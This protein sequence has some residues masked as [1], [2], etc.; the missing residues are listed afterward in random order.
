[1]NEI[2]NSVSMFNIQ[3]CKSK[4]LIVGHTRYVH[5]ICN[6]R[7]RNAIN[8]LCFV[9]GTTMCKLFY[10]VLIFI[11]IVSVYIDSTDL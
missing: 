10:Y 3:S 9:F 1:M 6:R 2:L 8:D 5:K 7:V 11:P 4:N